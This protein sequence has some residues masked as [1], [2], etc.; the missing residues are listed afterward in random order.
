MDMVVKCTHVSRR[1]RAK[2][3]VEPDTQVMPL[4]PMMAA[5]TTRGET[6]RLTT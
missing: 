5:F 4:S 1:S 2:R 6:P 3:N